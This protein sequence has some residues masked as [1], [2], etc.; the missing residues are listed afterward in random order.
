MLHKGGKPV[1]NPIFID[2]LIEAT[3]VFC[4]KKFDGFN[5]FNIAG[6]ESASIKDIALMIASILGKKA[7]FNT[8]NRVSDDMVA[9][10][11]KL[12][13]HYKPKIQLKQGLKMTIDFLE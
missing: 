9:S 11:D 8:S 2:D 1:I 10:I 3:C 7:K 13:N 12:N 4:L 6:P 5:V